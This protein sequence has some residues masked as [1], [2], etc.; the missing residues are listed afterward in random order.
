M[1]NNNG[2]GQKKK[3]D[4]PRNAIAPYCYVTN[5]FFTTEAEKNKAINHKSEVRASF[6]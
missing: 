2:K 1:N 3:G 5:F 6:Y 4:A